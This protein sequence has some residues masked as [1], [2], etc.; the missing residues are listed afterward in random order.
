MSVVYF[1]D[2]NISIC[3]GFLV[4]ELIFLGHDLLSE[5]PLAYPGSG[6]FP[7]VAFPRGFHCLRASLYVCALAV[8]F[9]DLDS[10]SIQSQ[11]YDVDPRFWNHMGN[12]FPPWL[13]WMICLADPALS[14]EAQL[15]FS[16]EG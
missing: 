1:L 2:A 7:S 11:S 9:L 8:D 5:L 15:W 13:E 10:I 16:P 3:F 4:C 12:Y 14:Q 6:R